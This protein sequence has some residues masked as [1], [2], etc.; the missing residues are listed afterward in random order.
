MNNLEAV[1]VKYA[2]KLIKHIAQWRRFRLL[3]SNLERSRIGSDV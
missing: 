3:V 1:V 2:R